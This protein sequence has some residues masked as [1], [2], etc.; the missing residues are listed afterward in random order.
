MRSYVQQDGGHIVLTPS[1]IESIKLTSLSAAEETRAEL[2]LDGKTKLRH[3]QEYL[4]DASHEIIF[5]D[6]S[7]H[8]P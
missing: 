4:K 8:I 2:D 1:L 5:I 6:Y 3:T 7:R